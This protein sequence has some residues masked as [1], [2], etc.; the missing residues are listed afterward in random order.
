MHF[1][2]PEDLDF[3]RAA[4]MD[5][6]AASLVCGNDETASALM[7]ALETLGVDIPGDLA[8]VGFDDIH[9]ANMLR[10]PLTTLHQPVRE[11][12][13]V[14][15]DTMLWRLS[16]PEAPPRTVAATGTLIVRQSCGLA[17]E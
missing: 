10:V 2:N 14:A 15:L 5:S 9:Y 17:G 16:H 12:G 7:P 6:D 8:I 11:I 1:G 4:V 13:N 3:V